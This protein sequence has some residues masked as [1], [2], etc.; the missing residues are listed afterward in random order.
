MYYYPRVS[1]FADGCVSEQ[2]KQE[3]KD[4]W[5]SKILEVGKY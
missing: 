5:G 2:G 4:F 1:V 3:Y